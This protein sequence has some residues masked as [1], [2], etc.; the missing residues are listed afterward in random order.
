MPPNVKNQKITIGYQNTRFSGLLLFSFFHRTVCSSKTSLTHPSMFTG[1]AILEST[2]VTIAAN[3]GIS[4]STV[5]NVQAL[6]QLTV[7]R[8]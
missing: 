5:L 8:T 1:L 6:F 2:A 4:L 7:L 3:A